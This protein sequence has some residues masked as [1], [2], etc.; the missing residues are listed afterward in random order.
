MEISTSAWP[1]LAAVAVVS[2][3]MLVSPVV[4]V[5]LLTAPRLEGLRVNAL[6]VR[7]DA[8]SMGSLK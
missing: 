7:V 1:A 6:S 5:G 8:V 2:V 3:R 4:H